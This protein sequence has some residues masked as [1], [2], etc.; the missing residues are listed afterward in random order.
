MG[1]IAREWWE[2]HGRAVQG[3][4]QH[5]IDIL[6]GDVSEDQVQLIGLVDGKRVLEIGCGGAQCSIAFARRGAIVTGVDFAKSEIDFAQELAKEHG[7]QVE[8][9]QQD[10]SDLTPIASE[11]QDIV[12]SSNAFIYVEDL[13][14][15]FSEVYR[16]LKRDGVFV[17]GG[18]HPFL[19]ILDWNTMTLNR[20]YFDTGLHVEG[21]ETDSPF[22]QVDRTIS[23]YFN[24]LVDSGFTVD[25]MLELCPDDKHGPTEWSPP[26][27][28]LA[29]VP[30]SI[31]FK[32]R[33]PL[34]TA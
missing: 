19:E 26:A 3:K 4:L 21:V 6:Y 8:L 30:S 31:I 25:R 5:P 22:S 32:A 28:L 17:F 2:R 12:F 1:E 29:R 10:M 33:K 9:L 14:A 20:S 24:V 7:V 23:D 34:N 18:T 11:S 15:C 27:D 16:V 13:T